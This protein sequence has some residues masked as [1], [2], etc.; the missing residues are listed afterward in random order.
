MHDSPPIHRKTVSPFL[1]IFD[2]A[3]WLQVSPHTL[4]KWRKDGLGPPGVRVGGAIRYRPEEVE[5]WIEAQQPE[6]S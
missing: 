3:D 6:R 2:V 4:R 1:T 5:A